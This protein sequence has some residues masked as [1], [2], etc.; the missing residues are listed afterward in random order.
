MP[1]P[2]IAPDTLTESARPIWQRADW[3]RA[4]LFG[5]LGIAYAVLLLPL[6]VVALVFWLLAKAL[7]RGGVDN[8][9]VP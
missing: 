6:A 9:P 5:T 8:G 7:D 4:F 1:L 2:Q 3:F